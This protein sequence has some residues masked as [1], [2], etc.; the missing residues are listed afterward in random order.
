MSDELPDSIL[1]KLHRGTVCLTL[2]RFTAGP[3]TGEIGLSV[4]VESEPDEGEQD[5][6]VATITIREADKSS[7]SELR[8][9]I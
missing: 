3:H 2:F 7:A 4:D 9:L 6:N 8:I 1:V 5:G